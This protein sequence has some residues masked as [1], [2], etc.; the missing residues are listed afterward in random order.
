[1]PKSKKTT[2]PV[3]VA[4]VAKRKTAIQPSHDQLNLLRA[5]LEA[6][7]Q[8]KKGNDAALDCL[9]IVSGYL[10]NRRGQL[11]NCEK[12][13]MT[14]GIHRF[15]KLSRLFDAAIDPNLVETQQ[16]RVL[17]YFKLALE[18]PTAQLVEVPY[19]SRFEDGSPPV[20]CDI[21]KENDQFFWG[22]RQAAHHA[23]TL[24]G[25]LANIQC[26]PSEV[27]DYF[28]VQKRTLASLYFEAC[29]P[30]PSP[31]ELQR[32]AIRLALDCRKPVEGDV[33]RFICTSF[34]IT[35][36]S[37]P[38]EASLPT[39]AQDHLTAVEIKHF[40]ATSILALV[41][42]D[43]PSSAKIIRLIEELLG[44]RPLEHEGL[45]F[46]SPPPFTYQVTE[47]KKGQT[48]VQ[49]WIGNKE[50]HLPEWKNVHNLLEC[51]CKNAG[52]ELSNTEAG[53]LEVT[54]LSQA[55]ITIRKALEVAHPGAGKWLQTRPTRWAKNHC[56]R[57]K[58]KSRK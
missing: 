58:K 52:I 53:G 14:A 12:E 2:N 8:S 10:G 6:W 39:F 49:L 19:D 44:G 41:C 22:L 54:N 28:A 33:R 37:S 18:D 50:V 51:L 31:T 42:E 1:M 55:A 36:T 24:A 15:F 47:P 40:P 17:E 21:R 16:Q 26:R 57:V 35:E 45:Q 3:Q 56:P 46:E 34:T 32:L 27:P 43:P 29:R 11:T 38:E 48:K 20:D 4:A 25:H 9:S 7:T 30:Y 13:A 5:V 23:W